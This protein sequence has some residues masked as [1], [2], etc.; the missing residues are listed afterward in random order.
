MSGEEG[1]PRMIV[2]KRILFTGEGAARE[3]RCRHRCRCSTPAGRR[4]CWE[5]SVRNGLD[6][7]RHGQRSMNLQLIQ[8]FELLSPFTSTR[9]VCE[10]VRLISP[11]AQAKA[12]CWMRMGGLE[13]RLGGLQT[14]GSVHTSTPSPFEQMY[15]TTVQRRSSRGRVV[16]IAVAA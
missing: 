4:G 6:M 15:Q 14:S 10:C 13:A 9:G 12:R 1:R 3:L 7:S 11:K 2:T 8:D 16:V 5:S